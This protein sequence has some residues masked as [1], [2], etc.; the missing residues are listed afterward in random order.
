ML[1][2]DN[3]LHKEKLVCLLIVVLPVGKLSMIIWFI[4][5]YMDIISLSVFPVRTLAT[6]LLFAQSTR[7]PT[8]NSH[9]HILNISLPG[10]STTAPPHLTPIRPVS[11][12]IRPLHAPQ[13]P[14]PQP[15]PSLLH[16]CPQLPRPLP[17]ATDS[18][19]TIH[20]DYHADF[21]TYAIGVSGLVIPALIAGSSEPTPTSLLNPGNPLPSAVSTPVHIANLSAALSRHPN[22]TLVQY[23][24]NGLVSLMIF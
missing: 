16:H 24:I 17:H 22:P 21:H 20:A 19:T 3:W 13:Q 10:H 1:T 5:T 7:Q 14:L 12:P 6:L 23:V 9:T 4:S 2:E 15:S 11:I 18:T 8:T